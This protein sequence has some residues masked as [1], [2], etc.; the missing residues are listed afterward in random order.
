MKKYKTKKKSKKI[1]FVFSFFIF[2]VGIY[3]GFN[4]LEK[5]K[6]K[7]SDKELVNFL[8]E[9]KQFYRIYYYG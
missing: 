8:L 6:I 7:I 4:M 5:S 9:K 2:V 1:R 3:I